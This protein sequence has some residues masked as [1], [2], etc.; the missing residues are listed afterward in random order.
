MNLK[1]WLA[2]ALVFLVPDANAM[3]IHDFGRMNDDDEATYV[4]LLVEGSAQMFK[5]QGQPDQARKVIA[6]FKT[7]GKDGGTY[8]FADELKQAFAANQRNAT[9]PNN[10]VP[11][12]QVEDAMAATLK[13]QGFPVSAGYLLSVSQGFRPLGLPRAQTPSGSQFH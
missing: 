4:T 9:N 13:A 8:Q 5:A 11:E 2:I 1:I 3:S 7:P 10:R 6:F 12:R